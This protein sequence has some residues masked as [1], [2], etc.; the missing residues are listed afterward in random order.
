MAQRST[1][2]GPPRLKAC[3]SYRTVPQLVQGSQ[4]NS[5]LSLRCTH[6]QGL[7]RSRDRSS[8]SMRGRVSRQAAGVLF[9]GQSLIAPFPF[10]YSRPERAATS[11]ITTFWNTLNVFCGS[12]N[13]NRLQLAR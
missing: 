2:I 7:A 13:F 6:A 8:P 12:R 4:G 3:L 5:L 11:K 10:L 1:V 9:L